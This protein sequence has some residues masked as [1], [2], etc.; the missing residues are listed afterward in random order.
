MMTIQA[1]VKQEQQSMHLVCIGLL[2]SSALCM[3]VRKGPC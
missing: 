2:R 3:E 1:Y